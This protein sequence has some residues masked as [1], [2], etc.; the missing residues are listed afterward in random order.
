MATDSG[1]KFIRRNR[2][3]RVHITYEDPYDAERL[4]ELPFVMGVL[5]D[6]SGNNPGVEKT[7][8]E[9][10]KFLEFDMDN[11]DNRMAAIQPGVT[12]RVANRLS[13]GSDEKISVNL[14]FNK[15][16]DFTPVAVAR[17]VPATAKLLE[18]REQ[19]ANLLRYMDG[20]VAAEDQL[21][22]LLADPQLMA[23]LRERATSQS[24]EPGTES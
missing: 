2:A 7:K 10:R 13:D 9:E 1:Q 24:T 18:A 8:V 15:M 22:K 23:A 19:L 17:Q 3:P 12:A 4:I 5:S 21:K 11:F 16:A 6:L 14:R 20:K